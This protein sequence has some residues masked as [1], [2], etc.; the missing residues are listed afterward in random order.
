LLEIYALFRAVLKYDDVTAKKRRFKTT[1]RPYAA[2]SL[3]I[4]IESINCHLKPNLQY[5]LLAE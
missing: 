3:I 1:D 4:W 2:D 5:R